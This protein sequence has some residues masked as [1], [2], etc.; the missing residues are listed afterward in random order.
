MNGAIAAR[1]R[2]LSLKFTAWP[3]VTGTAGEAE[4]PARMMQELRGFDSVW[5]APVP[6]GTHPRRN[7]FALK[8]GK[9]AATIVLTGHFDVVPVDDYGALPAFDVEALLPATIARLKA[10]GENPSALADFE[11]GDF[12]PGRGLLDMK[13][14]LAA[15]LAAI[16]AYRGEATLLFIA[17]ADEENRSAGARAA[18]PGLHKAVAEHHLAIKLIINLDAI[19][20]Q[21]DGAKAKVITYGSIGKQLLTAFIVGKEAHAGYPQ[22]GVNAAYIGAELI[23]ALEGNAAFVES[24]GNETTAAPTTLCA[25]DLKQGYNVTT[26]HA[27]WAYWNTMQYRK[28]GADVLEAAMQACSSALERV[29]ARSGHAVKLLTFAEF[30]KSLPSGALAEAAAQTASIGDLDL[31]ELSKRVME[32]LWQRSGAVGPAVILG[33]GSIPYLAVALRD[34]TLRSQIESA[35]KPFGIGALDYFAGIS[36]MSFLGEARGDIATVATNTPIWGTGFEMPEAAGFPTINLGPWGRDYHHWLER[37]H[38]PYA[39]ETLPKALLAVI[40]AVAKAS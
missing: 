27:F 36:D 2:E 19:S 17:V 30:A 40:E 35:V 15:G 38:A 22:D 23:S 13:A 28:S 6:G 20:D 37:L 31:P 16:E 21:K 12:L 33:F 34:M 29:K 1:A 32:L 24:S 11:S 25:K 9:T 5:L 26:P 7:L 3:S 4:F 39:F 18:V 14:G 8:R 10:T